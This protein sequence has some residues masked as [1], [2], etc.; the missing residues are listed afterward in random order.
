M[1]V[2]I[3]NKDKMKPG[4]FESIMEAIQEA[5]GQKPTKVDAQN[6]QRTFFYRKQLLNILKGLFRITCPD[7]WSKDYMLDLLLLNGVFSMQDTS[8]GVVPL[9]CQPF[10]VNVFE[11][12]TDVNIANPVLGT[13][14][15]KINVDCVLI[16]LYD[17]RYFRSFN[18]LLDIY[19]AKLALCDSS[20]DVNLINSKVAYIIDCADKKQA[21]EAKL[22]Y[23]K[24]SRGEPAV[25]YT[26]SAML[27]GDKKLTLSKTDVKN[28]YVADL[29]QNEKRS[30]MNEFLTAIGVNN[31]ATEKKERLV[32]DEANANNEELFVDMNYV[33]ENIKRQVSLA[34]KMFPDIN[35]NI[36]IP[37]LDRIEQRSTVELNGRSNGEVEKREDGEE[38]ESN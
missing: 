10:G 29:I 15:K 17:D 24:L 26:D 9:R 2:F 18:E 3:L 33:Y 31:V 23:D 20:I 34:N 35:F 14:T 25:F 38:S 13:F 28:S 11:R 36:E 12:P 32:T 8:M 7:E 37:T 21:D 30:I 16:Y 6:A 27:N 5:F 1:G 22:I 4:M 19:S